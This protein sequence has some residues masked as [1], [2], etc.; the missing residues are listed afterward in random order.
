M[1]D[2]AN[3]EAAKAINRGKKRHA[4]EAE[5]EETGGD[6]TYDTDNISSRDI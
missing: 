4:T 1:L 5:T 6:E 2:K 3:R